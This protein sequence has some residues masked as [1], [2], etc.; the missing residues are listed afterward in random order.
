MVFNRAK[1]FSPLQPSFVCFFCQKTGVVGKYT[2]C[3][4]AGG[5]H[6]NYP[7]FCKNHQF[8]VIYC[9]TLTDVL[10]FKEFLTLDSHQF[11]IFKEWLPKSVG[12]VPFSA[13]YLI[14]RHVRTDWRTDWR[15]D[16]LIR[17]G[18]GNLRFLQVNT[19]IDITKW[20]GFYSSIRKNLFVAQT[21]VPC[22]T[23]I[24]A[25]NKILQIHRCLI[26]V[27]FAAR[28][29]RNP[30]FVSTWNLLPPVE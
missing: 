12:L 17:V 29:R 22:G 10:Y 28:N 9:V 25:T 3:A 11:T 30:I 21:N 2:C 6:A 26:I 1:V 14:C 24:C 23:F 16:K 8:H 18:L 19:Q 15:T 7:D 27:F 4:W 20:P 5:T 13:K